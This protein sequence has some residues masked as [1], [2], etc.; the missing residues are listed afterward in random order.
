MDGFISSGRNNFSDGYL[1]QG[2]ECSSS[3]RIAAMSSRVDT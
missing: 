1:K 3:V 2:T